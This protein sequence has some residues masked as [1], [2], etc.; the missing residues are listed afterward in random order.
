MRFSLAALLILFTATA[1]AADD[2]PQAT[3]TLNGKPIKFPESAIAD[4]LKATIGLLESCSAESPFQADEFSKTLQ[5]DHV[6]L[7]FSRPTRVL[8]MNEKIEFREL[9]FRLPL[10]TGVF[11]LR[12]GDK[13]RRY[14]KYQPE[15]QKP[16][17]AWL[18]KAQPTQSCRAGRLLF[19]VQRSIERQVSR[20]IVFRLKRR[21]W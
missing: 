3:G 17:V 13:W 10:N 8:V 2:V 6:R 19:Q 7:V 5:Q 14:S 12:A 9:V 18:R 21:F 15:K 20:E 16:F 1:H 4:G 11:W